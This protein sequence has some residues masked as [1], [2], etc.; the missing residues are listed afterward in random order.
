M[1]NGGSIEILGT[2]TRTQAKKFGVN[3]MDAPIKQYLNNIS[4][5]KVEA[6][7]LIQ[8][9]I[10]HDFVEN[11]VDPDQGPIKN[12]ILA[13]DEDFVPNEDLIVEADDGGSSEEELDKVEEEGGDD[14]DHEAVI[15]ES[16]I[17]NKL[18]GVPSALAHAYKKRFPNFWRTQQG[19]IA[20]S[21][22][23]YD[24][25][26][27]PDFQTAE[28]GDDEESS[29]ESSDEEEE[30]EIDETE[31]AVAAKVTS[32]QTRATKVSEVEDL[33]EMVEDMAIPDE[34]GDKN[35]DIENNDDEEDEDE[36]VE[37]SFQQQLEDDHL[38]DYKSDEDPDFE[39]AEDVEESTEDE[40]DMSG[41]SSDDEASDDEQ[42]E[43]ENMV[44]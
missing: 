11:V 35:A 18:Q 16:Q 29:S 37:M 24:Q 10:F 21:G 41:D 2:Q 27:D 5:D 7:E 14:E 12:D 13:E 23:G 44:E 31:D 38:K 8:D 40:S 6:Q 43:E 34:D 42:E 25:E 39:P 3:V 32:L 17:P 22:H 30:C 9:R 15:T 26:E 20:T 36:V 1:E 33:T 28:E 4:G 19:L